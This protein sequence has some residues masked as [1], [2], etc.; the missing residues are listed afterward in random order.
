MNKNEKEKNAR[1]VANKFL[2]NERREQRLRQLELVLTIVTTTAV[3]F[4]AFA[5]T[6]LG[7]IKIQDSFYNNKNNI[8]PCGPIKTQSA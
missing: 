1:K 4:I 3:I 6:V 2:K 7:I 8:T 5:I